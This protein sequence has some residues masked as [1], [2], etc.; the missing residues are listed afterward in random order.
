M[1]PDPIQTPTDTRTLAQ[2]AAEALAVQD[3]CN[4]SGVVHGWSRAMR[5]LSQLLPDLGTEG[6][7]RHPVN[8]LWASKVTHL[9]GC[10]RTCRLLEAMTVCEE[11]AKG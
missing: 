1:N 7:N 2:L 3:A 4:L 9:S 10:D 6:R 5:R 11:L 8:V